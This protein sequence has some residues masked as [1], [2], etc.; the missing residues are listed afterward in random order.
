MNSSISK[1]ESIISIIDQKENEIDFRDITTIINYLNDIKKIILC[2]PI[3]P[4]QDIFHINEVKLFYAKKAMMYSKQHNL[5]QFENF[6]ESYINNSKDL[7]QLIAN[8][9]EKMLTELKKE[10]HNIMDIF[11]EKEEFYSSSKLFKTLSTFGILV[12]TIVGGLFLYKK[13]K[14]N[15]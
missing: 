15:K 13:Y 12:A 3:E 7:K 1:F 5:S 14:L 4:Q 9:K 10:D 8:Q 2:Q 6:F 11:S